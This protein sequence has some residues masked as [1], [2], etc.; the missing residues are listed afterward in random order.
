MCIVI[1]LVCK[2]KSFEEEVKWNVD[3]SLFKLNHRIKILSTEPY[4]N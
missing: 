1:Y 3:V 2:V 4:F